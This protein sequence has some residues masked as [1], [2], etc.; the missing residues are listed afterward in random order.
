MSKF[1]LST[2]EQSA[3][4]QV[5][6]ENHPS[7]IVGKTFVGMVKVKYDFAVNGGAVSTIPLGVTLPDNAIIFEGCGDIITAFTSTG[8]TGTI[9]LNA[10]TGGDLLA[11][12]DADTLA[13]VFA[14]IP[15]GS[16]ASAVKLTAARE[17]AIT[18]GTAAITAGKAVFFLFYMLSD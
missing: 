5:I 2:G 4:A 17:I 6:G 13:G 3:S 7:A 12:V 11:A 16:A 9:A 1:L 18:I 8:G 14:I 15:V 10:N